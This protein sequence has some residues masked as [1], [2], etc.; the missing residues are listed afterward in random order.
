MAASGSLSG[1]TAAAPAAQEAGAAQGS[2]HD[3]MLARLGEIGRDN[4][5][6]KVRADA[7]EE[8][9]A[10]HRALAP[11][12]PIQTRVD[13]AG[14]LAEEE[15]RSGH[16]ATAIPLFETVLGALPQLPAAVRGRYAV[17]AVFLLGVTYLRQAQ[18]VNCVESHSADACIL[19]IRGS[20]VHADLRYANAAMPLFVD[21]VRNL[22]PR[23]P[24]HSAAKWLLN[25]AAMMAGEYPSLLTDDLL[26]DP[27]VFRSAVDFPRFDNV[28]PAAGL[29]TLSYAGGVIV[30]DFDGDELLDVI[31]SSL[32]PQASLNFLHNRGDGHFDDLTEGANLVGIT[33]GLNLIQADYDNDGDVDVLVLRGAWAA[34]RGR[35][36]NSLLRNNGDRTFTDVTY[37]AGL[38][39]T[40]YPTQTAAWADFDNDGDLDLYI[41]NESKEGSRYP[42]ELFRNDGAGTFTEIAASAGVA[43]QSWSKGVVWGDVDGDDYPDLYVSNYGGPNRLYRNNHDAT[44]TDIAT[45]LRVTEPLASFPAW[46]WDVNNDGLLDLMVNGYQKIMQEGDAPSVWYVAADRL[47]MP[48]D[49]PMPRLYLGTPEGRFREATESYGLWHTTLPMGANFGDLD[50]DGWLDFFLGT[51]YPGY[52]GLMPNVMYRNVDGKRFDDVTLA[53]GFGHLQKGHGVAFADIDNDGDQDVF[54]EMGGMWPSDEYPNAL[55]ANPGFDH[56]WVKIRL[57]GTQSNHYGV[58]AKIRVDFIE[59]DATRS[60]YRIIGSG[61]SFGASPLRAEIGLG[62]A[63][64]ITRVQVHWP[65]SGMT[66]QF[67]ALELDRFYEI[68]EGQS[69]PRQITLPTFALPGR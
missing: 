27:S 3:R 9:R 42:S 29:A 40:Q 49:A 4:L 39:A 28:A 48:T 53:G 14:A 15:L 69:A 11:D 2:G 60:V 22:P 36:I 45:E 51:G 6:D 20:G 25:L 43:N 59:G 13:I 68:T 12:A 57:V 35:W 58:G 38:G 52:E 8:T 61:G 56:R 24:L 67:D 31:V 7:L 16:F 1:V 62:A 10:A 65:T 55:F 26:I 18:T 17:T 33:G 23:H 30:D 19:P 34:Q 37:D 41:G 32:D 47:G 21:L 5:L 46:F 54:A 50:N 63:T 44:F 66:Q 64:A